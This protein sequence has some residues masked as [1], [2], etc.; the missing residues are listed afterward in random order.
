M[1]LSD[2][3]TRQRIALNQTAAD[4]RAAVRAAGDL[5]VQTGG[6]EPRYVDAMLRAAEELGPYIVLAPGLALPHARPQDGAL[7]ACLA[8]VT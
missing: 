3:L 5:L 1:N 8:L 7:Q 6:V 2:L 4:W